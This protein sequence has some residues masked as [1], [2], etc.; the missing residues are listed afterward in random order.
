MVLGTKTRWFVRSGIV[1]P[2]WLDRNAVRSVVDDV[3]P[4]VRWNLVVRV[5][6]GGRGDAVELSTAGPV[7]VDTVLSTVARLGGNPAA[8]DRA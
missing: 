5:P 2:A 7:D 3:P 8:R 6:E 4:D 1:L